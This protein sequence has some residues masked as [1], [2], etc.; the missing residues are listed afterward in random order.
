MEILR[1]SF[2]IASFHKKKPQFLWDFLQ[3]WVV[4]VGWWVYNFLSFLWRVLQKSFSANTLKT[5]EFLTKKDSKCGKALILA[6]FK[7]KHFTLAPWLFHK[8]SL[9]KGRKWHPVCASHHCAPCHTKAKSQEECCVFCQTNLC[10]QMSL[11]IHPLNAHLQSSKEN[12]GMMEKYLST[13]W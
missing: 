12:W 4:I 9:C 13:S 1:V 5:S 10:S 8:W 11:N 7:G 6:F 2:I 3:M